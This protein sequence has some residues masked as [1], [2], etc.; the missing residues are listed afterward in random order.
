[1]APQHPLAGAGEPIATSTLG[2]HRIV[3]IA[4][5]S[6]TGPPRT[7]GLID[8]QD[9]LTVHDMPA[10]LEAQLAGLGCGWLPRFLA[11]PE[12]AAGRLVIKRTE[13]PRA[14]LPMQVAW[15]TERP[16]KALVWWLKALNDG[17]WAA[18][19]AR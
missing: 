10:K 1:V 4:D 7:M 3:A 14:P 8:G 17:R 6:R 16:G 2:E 9:S 11:A 12:A 5:S 15:C 13:K 18:L 19:L